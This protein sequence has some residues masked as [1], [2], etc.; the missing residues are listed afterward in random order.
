[1]TYSL[2]LKKTLSDT[3]R[4]KN[5]IEFFR[6]MIQQ[7]DDALDQW[8]KET[9][10]NF[11]Y[12]L[13]WAN[14]RLFQLSHFRDKVDMDLRQDW[15]MCADACL[16]K[17]KHAGLKRGSG[18]VETMTDVIIFQYVP[19]L[20]QLGLVGASIIYFTLPVGLVVLAT[21]AAYIG[22]SLIQNEK[23]KRPNALYNNISD[24]EKA[25]ISDSR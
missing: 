6:A 3:G 7:N 22:F 11:D 21:T 23:Q 13:L 25:N 2:H 5:E 17:V 1:M 15:S 16:E 9:S 19:L 18:A 4:F 8:L 12:P 14:K 10:P 24:L 20:F